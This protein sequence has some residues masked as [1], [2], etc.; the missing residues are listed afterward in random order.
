MKNLYP[1]DN[2]LIIVSAFFFLMIISIIFPQNIIAQKEAKD[3]FIL[4]E[5]VWNSNN[6]SSGIVYM[7]GCINEVNKYYNQYKNPNAILAL[8]YSNR[9]DC[10]FNLKN[11]K[12]AL[13][14]YNFSYKTDPIKAKTYN[15]LY[16]SGRCK[17]NLSEFC[18]AIND[19][20]NFVSQKDSVMSA[21]S[22]MALCNIELKEYQKALDNAIKSINLNNKDAFRFFVR[23]LAYYC[24]G[25]YQ[26]S[27]DDYNKTI[28]L[29]S[30]YKTDLKI[31]LDYVKAMLNPFL[32]NDFYLRGLRYSEEDTLYK[33][34]IIEFD[35]AIKMRNDS[36]AYYLKRGDC[37]YYLEDYVSAKINYE[38]AMKLEPSNCYSV[39]GLGNIA[40]KEKNYEDAIYYFSEAID[41]FCGKSR[42]R[43]MF[44]CNRGNT[45]LNKKDYKNALNDYLVANRL[46]GDYYYPFECLGRYFDS[47]YQFKQAI[48]NYSTA[49]NLDCKNSNLYIK[50]GNS[51]YSLCQFD[52]AISD[53][54]K[55]IEID[56]SGYTYRG[57]MNAMKLK[58]DDALND[59]KKALEKNPSDFE[60]L[61]IMGGIYALS[62]KCDKLKEYFNFPIDENEDNITVFSNRAFGY[63]LCG[64]FSEAIN[65]ANIAIN[66]DSS[67]IFSLV[68]RA[69]ANG[70]LGKYREALKD[71]ETYY[72]KFSQSDVFYW[73][74]GIT[75]FDMGKYKESI[76]D[77][78]NA[79]KLNPYLDSMLRGKINE[80][81]N[82][83]K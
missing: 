34:A 26:N 54:N 72:L 12:D 83:L 68:S 33:D 6:W 17:Y 39:N 62:G 37:Y 10:Y 58:F 53:Y 82:K 78:E 2:K 45:Y 61:T 18:N 38:K 75:F 13:S 79:I 46:D 71:Y 30:N 20:E 52:N 65:N 23:G 5:K 56:G 4:F 35:I 27:L 36:A 44:Y 14:D 80:A 51:Y 64:N 9:G 76:N 32:A 74:R 22:Y 48:E 29:D 1:S 19:F 60:N 81:K 69:Y 55:A 42:S 43:A 49:L 47:Q 31:N 57:V 63:N 40:R 24:L 59:V 3:Y 11:Y 70:K 28:D 73:F 67:Y 8:A 15:Y 41:G 50:R 66:L 25:Q 77:L 21:Y 16:W 7:N